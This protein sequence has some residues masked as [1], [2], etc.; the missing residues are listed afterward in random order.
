MKIKMKTRI[1]EVE[2]VEEVVQQQLQQQKQV[3]EPSTSRATRRNGTWRIQPCSLS[4]K[5]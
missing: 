2:E 3:G 4:S 1:R 5:K